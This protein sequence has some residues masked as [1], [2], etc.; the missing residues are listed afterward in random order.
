MAQLGEMERQRVGRYPETLRELPG[1]EPGGSLAYE[2]P[3]ELEAGRL[4]EGG[5]GI[6]G[7]L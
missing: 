6:H 5:K 4:G 2:D 7:R 1:G 3:E